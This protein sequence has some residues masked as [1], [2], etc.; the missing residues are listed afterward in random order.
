MKSLGRD[1]Y[2]MQHSRELAELL[3]RKAEQDKEAD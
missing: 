2:S 3:M 1:G